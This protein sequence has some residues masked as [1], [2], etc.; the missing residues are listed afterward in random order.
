VKPLAMERKYPSDVTD[1]QWK[2]L[3]KRL[4]QKTGSRGRP[5]LDRRW[6]LNA[7]LY[8]VRTGCQCAERFS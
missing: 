7:I 4:P 2:V 8:V 3:R 1:E 6:V 5:A